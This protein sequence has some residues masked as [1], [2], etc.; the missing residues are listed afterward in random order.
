MLANLEIQNVEPVSKLEL[1]Y[2]QLMAVELLMF[3]YSSGSAVLADMSN[4]ILEHP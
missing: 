1:I 4:Q 2:K 3:E